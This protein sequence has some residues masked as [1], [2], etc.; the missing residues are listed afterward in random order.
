MGDFQKLFEEQFPVR[1]SGRS[2]RVI[3][4]AFHYAS[5]NDSSM[6]FIVLGTRDAVEHSLKRAADMFVRVT[7]GFDI[8]Y[9][10]RRINL[11]NGSYV[12]FMTEE[13]YKRE[14]QRGLFRGLRG[15]KVYNDL[16]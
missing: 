8:L 1:Q 3:L 5:K 10:R 2:F 14:E 13:T 4:E 9:E 7:N 15:S 12:C 6:V 16:D 11:P